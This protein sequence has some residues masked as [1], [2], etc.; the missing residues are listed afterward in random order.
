MLIYNTAREENEYRFD[1]CSVSC[2]SDHALYDLFLLVI[3][4]SQ[5][6]VHL[7]FTVIKQLLGCPDVEQVIKAQ[8]KS[9]LF[10]FY[11][12]DCVS[13]E[14][15]QDWTWKFVTWSLWLRPGLHTLQLFSVSLVHPEPMGFHKPHTPSLFKALQWCI[16][17]SKLL[18]SFRLICTLWTE[19]VRNFRGH[20]SS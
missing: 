9:S 14:T 17:S 2:T 6:C 15:W 10:C 20:R 5:R 8:Y 12:N 19:H 11:R 4:Y 13:F 7:K 3:V 18:N 1:F 16:K